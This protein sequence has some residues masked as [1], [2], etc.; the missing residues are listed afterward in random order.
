MRAAGVTRVFRSVAPGNGGTE[1]RQAY[2]GTV[3]FNQLGL[4]QPATPLAPLAGE[5][6]H[7]ER[8]MAEGEGAGGHRPV[9]GG[10]IFH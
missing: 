9:I 1:I 5:F 7:L 10:A 6:N 4:Q 8:E 3:H 2:I